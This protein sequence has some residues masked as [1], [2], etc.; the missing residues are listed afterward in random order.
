MATGDN[1]EVAVQP[2]LNRHPA[3]SLVFDALTTVIPGLRVG[4]LSERQELYADLGLDSLGFVRLLIELESK[5]DIQLVD[6]E[7]MTIELV[8]VAD[9]VDLVERISFPAAK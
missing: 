5:L 9:L 7:L 3:T 4:E 6:E 8:N 1:S 2:E